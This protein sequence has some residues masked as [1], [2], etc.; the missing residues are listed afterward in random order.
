RS[1]VMRTSGLAAA[2]R[3]ARGRAILA[4]YAGG[5]AAI[6]LVPH[7]GWTWL[8]RVA[9]APRAAGGARPGRGVAGGGLDGALCHPAGER[10]RARASFVASRRSVALSQAREALRAHVA[11]VRSAIVVGKHAELAPVD[12]IV[13][14]HPLIHG[15]EGELWRAI[16][17]EACAAAGLAVTRAEA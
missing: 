14:A 7:T 3:F 1:A 16:F 9:G 11:G 6:G 17:A 2:A 10:A 15:A 4:R 12:R 5:M 8:G 13:A